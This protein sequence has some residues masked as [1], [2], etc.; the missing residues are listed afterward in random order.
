[1]FR[2]KYF[3]TQRPEAADETHVESDIQSISM[4]F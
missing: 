3:V 2:L 1:M 4:I